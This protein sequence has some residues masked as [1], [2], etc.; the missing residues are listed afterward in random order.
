VCM[1]LQI[2]CKQATEFIVKRDE[3][4]LSLK[5]RCLLLLHLGICGFCKFFSKQSKF[6]SDNSKNIH[7]HVSDTLSAEE[8]EQMIANLQQQ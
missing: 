3:G 5:N 4:K 2:T 6:I 8:K 1:K 7:R